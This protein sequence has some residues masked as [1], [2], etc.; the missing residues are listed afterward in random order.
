MFC[1]VFCI[2][3]RGYVK[4]VSNMADKLPARLSEVR[5]G[6]LPKWITSCSLAPK[7]VGAAFGRAHSKFVLKYVNVKRGSIAP[8]GMFIAVYIG[9]S[10]FWRYGETKHER[11]RVYHW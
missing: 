4:P 3:P 10:Y 1:T 6:Q 7:N 5:L 2:H 11:N 9:V 8:V